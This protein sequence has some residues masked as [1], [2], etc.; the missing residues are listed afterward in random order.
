MAKPKS[1][2]SIQTVG[3]ALRML[4]AFFA[5]EERDR[6][7]IVGEDLTGELGVSELSRRL[8]LHKNNV[9]RLLATLEEA[10]YV[11]QSQATE[12]YRLGIRCLELGQ[13]FARRHT[14]LQRVRPILQALVAEVG[15]SAH[16]AQLRDFEV[17]HMD[18][19]QS[20]RPLL[21][22]PRVGQRAP[23]HC[24][25]IG[26][27]LVACGHPELR[28]GYGAV[29]SDGQSLTARTNATIVDSHKLFDTF[30]SVAAQG[31]AVDLE[32]FETG[33]RCVAAPVRNADGE[34]IAAIS[35]SGP[36]SRLSQEALFGVVGGAVVASA[37]QLSLELGYGL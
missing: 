34:A 36:G 14:L 18:G 31:F 21:A 11:E 2:Y 26:K 1:D 32:E 9:F 5:H 29:I 8:G 30:S 24:T 6:S 7:E 22:A 28:E 23:A 35:I 25:A 37:D 3:N 17:V 15:E 12:R 13:A 4:E 20:D 27:V 10:G 19:V 33:M 16:V